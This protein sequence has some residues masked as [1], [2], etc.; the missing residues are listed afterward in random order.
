MRIK[1]QSAWA[2]V[3]VLLAVASVTTA[4]AD[5]RLAEAAK[6][7]DTE[8]VR[9]L[10]REGVPVNTPPPDGVTALHWAALGDDAEMADLLI[11][12]GRGSPSERPPVDEAW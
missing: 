10:L 1:L 9:T 11:R 4:A 3:A 2:A 5:L 12:L 8:A 6:N 7:G